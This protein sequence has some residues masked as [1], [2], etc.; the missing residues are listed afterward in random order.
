MKTKILIVSALLLFTNNLFCADFW[1]KTGMKDGISINQILAV[2]TF[3][4]ATTPLSGIFKSS[5]KGETW[6]Q[7]LPD[8]ML[9][10][11]MYYHND[12]LYACINKKGIY[13][14]SD[15]G[16]SW[17]F[18]GLI[19][20]RILSISSLYIDNK[21]Y[22]FVAG[23]ETYTGYNNF[24][25]VWR[26]TNNG[27]GWLKILKHDNPGKFYFINDTLFLTENDRWMGTK[28][29]YGILFTVN[30]GID[31]GWIDGGNL[32]DTYYSSKILLNSKNDI[33]MLLGEALY[34]KDKDSSYKSLNKIFIN[35][36]NLYFK[37]FVI[38]Y[39]DEI[40]A[41]T[42]KPEYGIFHSINNGETID[43]LY[44]GLN[45]SVIVCLAVDND[46][47]VYAGSG[48]DG[49]G[50]Y[51]SSKS[52][53]DIKETVSS[54][55]NTY[56]NPCNETVNFSFSLLTPSIV[57]IK[58]YDNLG[59]ELIEFNEYRQAGNQI[60][61]LDIGNLSNGFYYYHSQIGT[62]ILSGKILVLR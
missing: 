43:E 62:N 5:N 37:D 4:Y 7:I 39:N 57:N 36:V 60:I 38:N 27:Y 18:F 9:C 34:L 53:T 22:I 44:S 8:S 40:F 23:H 26:T 42:G 51:R 55:I 6:Q 29:V 47:F 54:N 21:G 25:G 59:N 17:E 61:K 12:L 24:A 10:D 41:S 50:I 33:I 3:L 11:F 1:E 28:S 20:P 16:N 58:I 19:D 2:D 30:D 45:N 15:N 49:K 52:T 56:P 48:Y 46:G 13:I 32:L 35:P 31:W 14:S